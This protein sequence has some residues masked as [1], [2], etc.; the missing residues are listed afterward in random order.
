MHQ[1][2]AADIDLFDGW[3]AVAIRQMLDDTLAE[4]GV[5]FGLTNDELFIAKIMPIDHLRI[6]ERMAVWKHDKQT[7]VPKRSN[8]A[9][10]R[11]G[12]IRHECHIKPSPADK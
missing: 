2:L 11:L 6:T 1:S 9:V 5:T 4:R 8:V 7:F 3:A 12:R 10:C